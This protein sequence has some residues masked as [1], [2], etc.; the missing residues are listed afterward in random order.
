MIT[1]LTLAAFSF[2]CKKDKHQAIEGKCPEIISTNPQP[3]AK[4]IPLNKVITATF[5]EKMDPATFTQS[6]FK[7][8]GTAAVPGTVSYNAAD[9]TLRFVPSTTLTSN[10]SYTA[11]ILAGA[12]D[13][14]GNTLQSD[15]VWAF[16]TGSTIVTVVPTVIS[17]DPS[18]NATAV[19]LNKV[20]SATFSEPMDASSI[21]GQ[22]FLLSQGSGSVA[23]TVSY[24]GNTAVF[25]SAA[26]LVAGTSYT[27]TITSVVQS[28]LGV[29]IASNYTW[30]FSTGNTTVTP[31]I[32]PIVVSTDPM[33]NANGVALTKVVSATFD[34]TM[35]PATISSASFLMKTGS[36]SVAGTV[37]YSGNTAYFDPSS[38][39]VAGATYNATITTA[40]KN[41][42]GTAMANDYVWSFNTV[43][44]TTIGVDLRS[45]EDFGIIAGVG[46]SNNA[47]PSVINDM[48]V[49]ISPGV[50]SSITGFPPATVV[51]GAIFASDDS[52]PAGVAAMLNQAKLDLNAAYLYAE[53]A[54]TPAPA[55]V[56]GDQGGLTLAPGIY[57]ST[58][59]LLIQSGDLTLDAGGDPNAFWIFQIA[60][61]FTSVGGAGGNVILSGGAQAKNVYWQ[62]GSSATIGDNTAFKGNVLALTSI[63]MGSGSTAVGRMLVQNGSVTL[64]NTNI[65]NKP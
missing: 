15:Y 31:V 58:S 8:M 32:A 25:T 48:N 4:E 16:T 56:S 27:A 38:N 50:R 18:N 42:T 47:G 34:Q 43:A 2:G 45:A 59:T 41:S 52:A 20:I 1:A 3:G 40:V 9:S 54:T 35:D 36:S 33:N 65:I 12:E 57:K 26:N 62:V 11:T 13:F 10:T 61:A 29:A 53:G 49:G 55:S 64:T 7:V 39:F 60:S 21:T 23:G 37:T 19:P 14:M 22:S 46:I 6:S 28:T 63:T 44:T 5:N 17:T 51:N 30:M 24:S